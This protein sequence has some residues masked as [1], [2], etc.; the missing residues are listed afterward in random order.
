LKISKKW[1]LHRQCI[2]IQCGVIEYID[3]VT[4]YNAIVTTYIGIVIH[5]IG[6]VTTYNG[7]VAAYNG[8]V[9]IKIVNIMGLK[10]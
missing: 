3:D 2:Q 9:A 4:L 6:I 7:I 10:L 1:H 5:N 8:N